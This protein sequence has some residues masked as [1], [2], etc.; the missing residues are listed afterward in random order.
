MKRIGVHINDNPIEINNQL[1][2]IIK[3]G[4]NTVQLFVFPDKK[5]KKYYDLF[6]KNLVKKNIIAVVHASYTINLASNWDEYSWWITQLISEIELSNYIGAFGVVVHLGKQMELS[7]EQAYN[8]M[9]SSLLYVH[10][11]TIKYKD[12]KIL[13]ETS[14]GQGTETCY[15][16]EDFAYFF[17]KFSLHRNTNIQDR[18]RI[19][20]DTCHIFSAGY[21]I[22][23]KKKI[24]M[25][26]DVFEELI[27]L[28][29]VALVHL[30]DSK[31]DLGSNVDR[32]ENLG[33]GFIGEIGLKYMVEFFKKINV[34]IVLETPSNKHY[35][36]IKNYLL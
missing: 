19:C 16:I 29:Y 8:N 11:K 17:K 10:N 13:I 21:D 5:Y 31:K 3:M 12:T 24:D 9:F 7:N 20:I 25:Y 26:L 22:K 28:K 15:K 27:G 35:S 18:F 30:N 1:D 33:L 23:T 36:E 32:H 2:Y 14:S 34:P 6:K 4:A